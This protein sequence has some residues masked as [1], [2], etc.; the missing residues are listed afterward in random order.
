M[1]GE[2]LVYSDDEVAAAA[3]PATGLSR[4]HFAVVASASLG[5]LF[6]WYDF[7]L[8][9][10]LAALIGAKFFSALDPSRAFVFALVTFATG[11]LMRP[12][13]A[14]LFGR[15]GDKLGRKKTFLA[16]ILVMGLSTATVGLMPT[17]KD[18]GIAAPIALVLLRVGQG[19]AAGGEYGG[20]VIYVAEHAPRH[21]RAL[22]TSFINAMSTMGLV[23]CLGVVLSCRYA[24]GAHFD[25]YGW[26]APFLIS[27]ILLAISVYVRLRLEES[28]V[29]REMRAEGGV[30]KS[31]IRDSFGDWGN[32]KLIL[33][34]L[35]GG[36]VG[37]GVIYYCGAFY[38]LFF[39]TQVLKVEPVTA[40][41]LVTAGLVAG[42]PFHIVFGWL[43]DRIGRKPVFLT[44]C[45]LAAL[46]IFPIYRTMADF[47]NP[48]L[49]RAATAQPVQVLADQSH[50][51]IRF[52]PLGLAPYA[53]PCDIA[54]SVPA[55]A[56]V[57][58]ANV[59]AK[60]GDAAVIRIGATEIKAPSGT[61]LSG[62]AFTQAKADFKAAVL[63]AFVAAGYPAA[64][65][66]HVNG[67]GVAAMVFLMMIFTTLT[68]APL[69]IWMVE[70]FPARVRYTSMSVPYHVGTGLFGGF[71]PTI[72]FALVFA[73]GNIFS[74][75]WYPL[76]CTIVTILVCA[77]ALPETRNLRTLK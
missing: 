33:K 61:G 14:A 26:R 15:L 74:G 30:S 3:A 31:P 65:A 32:F 53:R 42:A 12:V 70:L 46:L 68:T 2:T 55:Q 58:Y 29:F 48:A 69:A 36:V 39:L 5:T 10:T 49:G 43:C 16:T 56:G 13:G 77:A 47:A 18:I 6:E 73:T 44:G 35:F 51:P 20:A 66:D 17:Y 62:A 40:N 23:L 59:D 54:K 57:P 9:G 4:S 21:R 24:F 38:S 19:L 71:L 34:T 72:M 64:P 76:L 75:L 22:Y 41:L 37:G 63:K 28:P 27:V 1:S 8:Y 25:D 50:C 60:I 52:D 67:L 45:V 7:Y 11:S